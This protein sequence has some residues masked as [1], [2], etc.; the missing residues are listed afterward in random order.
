MAARS[1]TSCFRSS[2]MTSGGVVVSCPW[3]GL[4]WLTCFGMF[5][6]SHYFRVSLCTDQPPLI[7]D[8]LE[9]RQLSPV[10]AGYWLER[11]PPIPSAQVR[12]PSHRNSSAETEGSCKLLLPTYQCNGMK[13]RQFASGAPPYQLTGTCEMPLPPG[14]PTTATTS[15]TSVVG[16]TSERA[17]VW[18]PPPRSTL[19]AEAIKVGHKVNLPGEGRVQRLP[20]HRI[21]PLAST[22]PPFLAW[23]V[24]AKTCRVLASLDLQ[25]GRPSCPRDRLAKGSTQ[26]SPR[27]GPRTPKKPEVFIQIRQGTAASGTRIGVLT[28]ADDLASVALMVLS[29]TILPAVTWIGLKFKPVKCST[30]HVNKRPI[31]PTRF[32]IDG[33]P[34]RVLSN[35]EAYQ[36]LRVPTGTP[37]LGACLLPGKNYMPCTSS[38]S[39]SWS[40]TLTLLGSSKRA[41]ANWRSVPVRNTSWGGAG[42]LPLPDFTDL[43][44]MAHAFH[45]LTSRERNIVHLSLRDSLSPPVQRLPVQIVFHLKTRHHL[46]TDHV[47]SQVIRRNSNLISM[48]L[49]YQLLEVFRLWEGMNKC[50]CLPAEFSSSSPACYVQ[51]LKSDAVA[52]LTPEI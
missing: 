52:D 37:I 50:E 27:R 14:V 19:F 45:G 21:A 35:G 26:R 9:D 34:L 8:L 5:P 40:S 6:S 51:H 48:H 20:I 33:I 49:P 31:R 23:T 38:W 29:K 13:V 28:Y 15:P 47:M 24:S 36:H 17:E 22:Q 4:I 16:E 42:F 1:T 12:P 25:V 11:L 43:I 46:L 44:A 32:E 18:A 39:L 2:L 3:P 7:E 10:G 30:L 41:C